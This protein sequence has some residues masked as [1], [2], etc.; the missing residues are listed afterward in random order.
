MVAGRKKQQGS[1]GAAAT[2]EKESGKGK[3]KAA[4]EDGKERAKEKEV[5][6]AS[7]KAAKGKEPA[8]EKQKQKGK[9]KEAREDGK[10]TAKAKQQQQEE[11]AAAKSA[12][13]QFFKIFFPNQ[14]GERLKIP[15]SFHRHL[16][17]QPTGLVSLKGPSGNTWQAVLTSDSEGLCFGQGWKEFVTDHSVKQGHFLVFTYDGLSKF[18]VTVFGSLGVVDPPALVAKPTNDVVIKIEDDE[19]VQGDMDAGGTSDTSILPPEEGNGI[20][21][22][23]TR[24]VNDLLEGGN[25]SKRHSS[26]AKNAEK[27][28]PEAIPRTSKD[29]S[30]VNNTEKGTPFSLLDESMAFNKTQIREKN[31]PKLGKFIVRRARQPVVISQ[32]RPVTQEEKDLALRRAKEFKSKNPFAVQT[33]MESYVYVG[34]FMNITCEFVRESLPRTSKKMT[35]WDPLGKPWEVNYVYYSDRSVASFSGGWGKF[36]LGNNLEKFDVCVFEL[37]KEDN[38]KV[39]IYRVV[40]E[41]TPL[42]RASSKD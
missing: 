31:M 35:L 3:E 42:L 38:I 6:G 10:E 33:M 14:S 4:R 37:F 1:R 36:A 28:R 8:K 34:F 17:E 23:R 30:T 7:K 5:T 39:H 15:A 13:Q 32:R 16:K 40:P 27:K 11:A 19:E 25:A 18:S 24:G 29:A 41:I 20:T 22:K 12:G 26:V 9:Q 2:P 21:R